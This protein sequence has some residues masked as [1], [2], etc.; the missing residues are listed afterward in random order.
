MGADEPFETDDVGE[1]LREGRPLRRARSYRIRYAQGDLDFRDIFVTDPVPLGRQ[2]LSSAGVDPDDGYS[3]FA[4]LASGDFEDIR[5]D[6]PFD[7]RERGAERFVAFRT[8][9]DFRLTLN[10]QQLAW[11][12]PLIN[13]SALYERAKVHDDQA[14]FLEVRGG[15]DRLIEREELIDLTAPGIERFITAPRPRPTFEI[16]VNARPRVVTGRQVT[17]EQI[18]ELAFPGS[19]DSNTIFSMTY[20]NAASQPHAGE[21]AAGGIVA[22]KNGSIFNVTQ[23]VRS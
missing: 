3:L 7:L 23:T 19:H 5:L 21:L 4:V 22:V 2:I 20:R 9:R 1:A 10:G 14:V 16:I 13:G 15:E 6:E 12:K 17:F 18:V 11:G 8:D